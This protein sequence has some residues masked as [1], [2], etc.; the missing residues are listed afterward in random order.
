VRAIMEMLQQPQEPIAFLPR[1][2][3]GLRLIQR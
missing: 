2:E 1:M 3:E